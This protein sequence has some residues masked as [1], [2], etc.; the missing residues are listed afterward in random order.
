MLGVAH[1][2]DVYPLRLPEPCRQGYRM[3]KVALMDDGSVECFDYYRHMGRGECQDCPIKA[4]QKVSC[5][6][7]KLN[8]EKEV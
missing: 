2:K 4:G 5:S 6:R 8:K 3:I 1:V 7:P